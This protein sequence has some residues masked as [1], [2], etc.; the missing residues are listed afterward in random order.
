MALRILPGTRNFS[1]LFPVTRES[2]GERLAHDSILR[3]PEIIQS[4]TNSQIWP[5]QAL[6]AFLA[7]DG[8]ASIVT[9]SLDASLT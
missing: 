7:S 9:K 1:V 4:V 3:H 2:G 8:N 6:T 5:C